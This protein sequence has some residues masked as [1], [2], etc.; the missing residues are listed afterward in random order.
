MA[1]VMDLTAKLSQSTVVERVGEIDWA[2]ISVSPFVIELDPTAVCDLACPG[3]ISE[4]LIQV[5]NSF[6]NERL[7]SLGQEMI[8]FGVKAVILIGGGE[9]LAHP[10]AG[11]LIQLLGSNDVHIGITTNGTFIDKW[12]DE[13]AEYSHW[14]RV[15]MD[16]SSSELF[17]VNRPSRGGK[18]KFNKIV[19]NM[20]LLA[21]RKKGKLGYS[22]LI[23][24]RADGNGVVSNIHEIY[25]AAQLARDIGCDYFE[26]KPSYQFREGIDHALMKHSIEDTEAAREE[27]A[28]LDELEG[29]S[30][31][32]MKAINLEHSFNKA[33]GID[34]IQ[35]KEYKRCPAAYLRTTVTPGG[36]YVCPYWRGKE[37]M[38]VGDVVKD[39]FSQVW[40][41][42]QRKRVMD[43]LDPS[44]DCTFHCLRDRS[45][46]GVFDIN[47]RLRDGEELDVVPEFDRFI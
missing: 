24:T 2:D 14:T 37:H 7:L 34:Q 32:V 20:H 40:N 17:R 39:S 6:S 31:K 13:I 23:Q 38:K 16:A 44:V 41:S 11:E 29:D 47:K 1:K 26:V 21:E 4:D 46:L 9:P 27:I 10:K 42:E 22:F 8:D 25:A 36:I 12:I 30:F 45:N 43:R 28:K 35:D 3:C 19:E 15:S 18:S 33:Y 5:G